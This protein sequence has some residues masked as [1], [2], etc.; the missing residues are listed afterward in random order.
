MEKNH[1]G[2]K[3]YMY[4]LHFRVKIR[5]LALLVDF[6][7]RFGK[8]YENWKFEKNSENLKSDKIWI[9]DPTRTT[10]PQNLLKPPIDLKIVP[11]C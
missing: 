9:F 11:I 8:N 7:E 3:A 5:S 1:S 6:L 4:A 10:A 2:P